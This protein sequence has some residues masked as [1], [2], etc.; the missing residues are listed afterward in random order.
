MTNPTLL[1]QLQRLVTLEL[2]ARRLE[3]SAVQLETIADEI[4]RLIARDA[5]LARMPL[6]RAE[7]ALRAIHDA[8]DRQERQAS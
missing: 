5:R 8:A 2:L 3:E 6:A 1:P 7:A 4:S